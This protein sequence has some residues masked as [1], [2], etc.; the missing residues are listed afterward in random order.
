MSHRTIFFVL[1]AV[2]VYSASAF[3][4]SSKPVL[5]ESDKKLYD[6]NWNKCL[7]TCENTKRKCFVEQITLCKEI[8]NVSVPTYRG[9]IVFPDGYGK[10]DV[11]KLVYAEDS[12]NLRFLLT[13][14]HKNF[15]DFNTNVTDCYP[16]CSHMKNHEYYDEDYRLPAL[17]QTCWCEVGADRISVTA[18]GM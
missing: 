14:D 10:C 7:Q 18:K 4:W 15:F 1:L 8:K 2:M 3:F 5:S 12:P 9:D 17:K 6:E 16:K 13:P 11:I